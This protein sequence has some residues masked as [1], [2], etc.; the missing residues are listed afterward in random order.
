[1]SDLSSLRDAF[2]EAILELGR[3]N[4]RVVAL[5]ADLAESL[6]MVK[7]H[8]AFPDRFYD[9]G[10]AEENLVGVAAGF[11]L[12]GFIPFAGS[13][14]CFLT[15]AYDHVR[16]SVC[17]NDPTSPA[18]LRGAGL[19]IVLVGSHGGVSNAADGASAHAL[20]DLAM[21]RAL[22]NMTILVPSDANEM[23][24]AVVAAAEHSGPVYLRL[25]RE[26]TPV[27]TPRD[28]PFRV[29]IATVERSGTDVT[30]IACGPQ[31][32]TALGAAERL[33]GSVSVE[34]INAATLQPFDAET[35]VR[36][37]KKTT[38]VLTVEDH[39]VNGGLGSAVAEALAEAGA[40]ARLQRVGHRSFGESGSYAD[41]LRKL[42]LDEQAVVESIRSVQSRS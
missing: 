5:A 31:V 41:V 30:V 12:G 1:M 32:A 33:S 34:V 28:R 22:P 27:F 3:K 17:Q 38:R 18:G 8:E 26:P 10:V 39:N 35:V 13:F 24:A 21:M 4:P 14:G 19:H 37:A 7:F 40:A 11:A 29:G 16:V 42:G 25:Y 15:R 6:R 23:T 36:S 20:E 9:V 2:G